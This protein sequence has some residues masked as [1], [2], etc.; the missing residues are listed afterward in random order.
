M[1][2]SP[3][4]NG[5]SVGGGLSGDEALA[6]SA[7]LS[8][9]ARAGLPLGPSLAAMAE[10]LPRGRLRRAMLALAR[11][12]EA[13]EPVDKALEG[14]GG[15]IPAHLRGLVAAGVRCGRLGEVL[16][17]FSQYAA[18]GLELRRRLRLNLAYPAFSLLITLGVF[19]FVSVA[20]V[21]K[22]E[23]I[24]ADFGIPLPGLTIVIIRLARGTSQIWQTL[25]IVTGLL[26]AVALGAYLLLPTATLR[27]IA[28]ELPILGGVWRWTSLAEFCHWLAML[29]EHRLPMPEALHLAGEAVQDSGI[30]SATRRMATDLEDGKSLAQAMSGRRPFPSRLPRLLRWGERRS[31]LPEV[32]H[33]AGEMFATRAAAQSN[34]AAAALAVA[35]FVVVIVGVNLIVLGLMLPMITLISKLSG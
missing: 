5:A 30:R 22:F 25:V 14:Q 24:F 32:L 19:W 33:M 17:E 6:L 10:E 23:A 4:S 9:L 2:D 11:G 3:L 27:G 12:L 28:A 18:T 29:L 20:V 16:G 15:R 26:L 34:F 35:C 7:R 8:G 21:P 1:S 13:G 31:S